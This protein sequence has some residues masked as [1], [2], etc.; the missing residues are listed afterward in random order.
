MKIIAGLGNPGAR[1]Q[2][3]RHNLGFA[4]VDLLADALQTTFSRTQDEA[5]TAR[6]YYAGLVV[7]LA[8][9][10]TFMNLSGRSVSALVRRNGCPLEN[11]LVFVDDRHLPL[12]RVRL[13]GE[14]SAGGHNGLKSIIQH[15][16]A[17]SF[18]RLRMGIGSEMPG[19]GD[20]TGFVL[21]HFRPEE[22]DAVR[23]MTQRAREAALC[24]IE[25]GIEQTMSRYNGEGQP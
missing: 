20:L 2:G 6:A 25:L 11:I 16:G 5:L 7:L 9:P 17:A 8:K 18:A 14:G 21:G 23:E 4:A 10:Q 15:L 1:Y 24:W 13:R 22:T 12:G 3:T 19:E